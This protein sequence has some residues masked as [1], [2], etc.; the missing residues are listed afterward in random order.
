MT[1][2]DSTTTPARAPGTVPA[3]VGH[4]SFLVIQGA[5]DIT[6]DWRDIETLRD[7]EYA[8][9]VLPARIT[10]YQRGDCDDASMRFTEYRLVRREVVD[11]EYQPN[12]GSSVSQ[13]SA[14]ANKLPSV[15]GG[16]IMKEG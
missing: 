3:I 15:V 5:A 8:R 13:P 11:C 7:C 12:T 4:R 9:R 6:T 16:T 10:E 1:T 2:T 14:G